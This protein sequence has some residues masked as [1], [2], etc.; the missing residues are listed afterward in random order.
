MFELKDAAFKILL[1]DLPGG[2]VGKNPLARAGD[3]GSI[4][5]LG[6]IPHAAEQL[7]P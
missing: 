7:S 4:P 2:T 1:F 5:D 3:T 6:K